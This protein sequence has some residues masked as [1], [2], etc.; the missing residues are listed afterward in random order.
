MSNQFYGQTC[1]K[2]LKQKKWT[3]PSDFTCSDTELI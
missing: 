2:G 3:L 1:K